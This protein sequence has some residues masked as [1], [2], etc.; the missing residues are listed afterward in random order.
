MADQK[1][2]LRTG[3]LHA[4]ID[5]GSTTA[6]IAITDD[7]QDIVFSQYLRHNTRVYDTLHTFLGNAQAA[8]GDRRL[9]VQLTGSAG[10]GISEQTTIPFIQEVIATDSIIRACHPGV[11]TLI[12]IGGEDSKMIFFADHKLPDI[13]MNGSCAGGTGAFIDQIATLL[14]VTP[15][16]LNELAQ[17]HTHL[18]PIASRCGVFAKTDVQ[19]L[20]ARK[21]PWEDI[22]ASIFHAV[23]VQC[24]NTLARGTT[25]A[26]KVM[27]CGG[28]FT[29]LP[30]LGR[31]FLRTI[32]MNDADAE[33]P[34]R[35][36][37]LPAMGAALTPSDR[38][39]ITGLNELRQQL[40]KAGDAIRITT[41][42]L[43]PLFESADHYENW[44]RSHADINIRR[45]ALEDYHDGEGF[46]GIDSGSTT[47]KI[48]VT[49][50]DDQ[51]LFSWYGANRGNPVETLIEGLKVLKDTRKQ[52]NP[53]LQIAR[54]AVTGYGEDLIRAAFGIDRG[55]VETI[56]HFTAARHI[57]PDVS[58]V[59]DIG[60]QDMKAIFIH[61]GIIN[62]IE[63]NEACSSGCG[64]FIE[65]FGHSL[66][67]TVA[68]FARI[69][70]DAE[71]PCDLGTR[72]TVF[73]NSKV[74]QSLRE[75]ASVAEISAGL[76]FSVIKNCLFKVLKLNDMSEL[77]DHI[78]LQGGTFKNPAVVRALELLSGKDVR[79]SDSPELMGAFGASLI[80]RQTHAAHPESTTDFID[81]EQ[82]DQ[83]TRF[84][85]R[86]VH[87]K[88]CENNC[89]ITRFT[90]DNRKTF[91]SGNKCENFFT[92]RGEKT[93]EGYN[94][95]ETKRQ[96]LFDRTTRTNEPKLTLGIPR[97]LNF[98]DN[99]PF[100]HTLFD[101][102]GIGVVLSA[103]STMQ[104]SEKGLG[105][106][107]SD[108]ICFPAKLVNGH[109]MDLG[110]RGI[111]RI[112]Y[113]IIIYEKKAFESA[114]NSF[115]CPI[116]SSY[117][118]VIDSAIN[119]ARKL[120][121]PFDKPVITFRDEDLLLKTCSRY[122]KSLGVSGS[123]VKKALVKALQAQAAFKT[124]LK[125]QADALI[126]KS[127]RDKS[128]LIVLA[129]RPYH[130]DALI[131]HRTPE[132]LAGLGVDVVPED[133]LDLTDTDDSP[134]QV[135]TQWSYPN[136]IF[137][138][139]EWTV[140]QPD[141][142]QFIQF[143]SFG[144]G[145]DALVTDETREILKTG[146]K[147]YTL[148]KIDEI[149]ST[150]S[151]RLRLRS[152]I[153]SLKLR[154]ERTE[155]PARLP[156]FNT[157]PFRLEDR[158]RT[159]LAPFFA[160]FYSPLIPPVFEVAG[161]KVVNLPPPDR[162][163]V[164]LGL[165]YA[166]N[167]ICYPA[168]IVIGDIIKALQTGKYR[169]DQIACGIT[170]TGGQ[171]RAS[172]YL[173]LI[174]KAMVSAGYGDIPVI[175]VTT[176]AGLHDQPGF[177]INWLKM[178]KI[179]FLSLI[180]ADS[181]AKLYYPTVV[182]EKHPGQ[183]AALRDQYL[184]AVQDCIRTKDYQGI[185][186]LLQRAVDAF[187]R[188]E[189]VDGHYPKIGIVGEIYVKYNSFGHQRIVDWLVE[190]QIE[191]VVPPIL[192]FFTQDFVN[193]VTNR[194]TNLRKAVFADV[195]AGALEYY[196]N[197][198]QH[199][200]NKT[201]QGFRFFTPFHDIADIA[202]KAERILSLV[203]QFGEGWLIAA[204]IAGL[205]DEGVQHVL[206]LQPFGCIANHVIS[207]GIETKIKQMYPEMNL[208]FL[209]FDSGTS[210]VNVL[211]RLYFMV[212]NVKDHRGV[213]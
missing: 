83:V 57:S 84:A 105:T 149:T 150:G 209:D 90:F 49:G 178:I 95:F 190:N 85:T 45:C 102:C 14:N 113:P 134:L 70:C 94:L 139:A 155:N 33:T 117:P 46:L 68:D 27:L 98:Y 212:K 124:A 12:D 66:D 210:E 154:Q 111:D 156:R 132:I 89:V 107:M 74:K 32:G 23:A 185:I 43:D 78:V 204:E 126:A 37:L 18:Y 47:T 29:F 184:L 25:I 79:Y 103:P 71:A 193:V 88:G 189:I 77:G 168:T 86:Q 34:D 181:L 38:P 118:E 44:C 24:M 160:D 11:R 198:F 182:R 152:M 1:H 81:L 173:P 56:A 7:R 202:A 208:L 200:V 3:M 183:S 137:K 60:G 99:Y 158:G 121:I 80:A 164:E 144:C 58:F 116:V 87:C 112:F 169:H 196:I 62:R 75:S 17:R 127:R 106:V 65:T 5:V 175:S 141:H 177:E 93:T 35:P 161:Y 159:I 125:T 138:A 129:G 165:R 22:A 211:N 205:A 167:D 147:N 36:E 109:I 63:L 40:E 51:L 92:S 157:P 10:M 67:Y 114:A 55:I 186:Q 199:K 170:Q 108:S 53:D 2:M 39:C 201:L 9:S 195:F 130:T 72:C 213:A 166:N 191:P 171:C 120:G 16:D 119:P 143:N 176:S 163:S 174:R 194:K 41:N 179:L 140:Q 145:P 146:H 172:N 123:R 50:R 188:I 59:L 180:Y 4:G 8:L 115:N 96:L 131:N 104:L 101:E 13:R 148:I 42:R 142:I 20:L 64:S 54:T 136:R 91:F 192:D 21:I 135:I 73:M 100:W 128:L 110:E 206:S 30:E 82:L 207:K 31:I 48:T 69:A 197:R 15:S 203:N 133:A 61:D 6:K 19:N 187:N 153:E 162:E 52:L 28:P 76:A 97:V 151:V 26:S 122:L